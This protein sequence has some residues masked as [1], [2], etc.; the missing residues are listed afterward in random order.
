MPGKCKNL[1]HLRAFVRISQRKRVE[2]NLRRSGSHACLIP[3]YAEIISRY[4]SCGIQMNPSALFT[5]ARASIRS[6][7][8]SG[9]ENREEETSVFGA[10]D[11]LR[12]CT[13]A[14]FSASSFFLVPLC[15]FCPIRYTL[16]LSLRKFTQPS[17]LLQRHA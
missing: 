2:I 14:S 10:R 12:F 17:L 4:S 11:I 1:F 5:Y 6:Q 9:F 16:N 13:L 7:S 8:A 15:I 3:Q